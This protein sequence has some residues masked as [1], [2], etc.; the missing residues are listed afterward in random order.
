MRKIFELFSTKCLAAGCLVLVL[1]GCAASNLLKWKKDKEPQ[2]DAQ[3]PAVKILCLW[4]PAEG[5]R[6]DGLPARGFAGQIFFFTGRSATPAE[7]SG[8]V[9]VYVFDDQGT[10]EEQSKPIHQ[11]DF[12]SDAWKV[13]RQ[14]TDL[15]PAYHVFVPYV[16]KGHH[17]AHCALRVRLK[18]AEG[19]VIFS[20]MVNVTLSG[21]TEES[22]EQSLRQTSA[23]GHID[24]KSFANLHFEQ[25]TPP[26][27]STRDRSAEQP[28]PAWNR[29]TF[30]RPA[31]GP[32]AHRRAPPAEWS[33]SREGPESADRGRHDDLSGEARSEPATRGS[34]SKRRH[35]FKSYTIQVPR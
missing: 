23:T 29:P 12:L 1:S 8:D 19:P 14:E 31:A 15:G 13:H 3:N 24:K 16:R 11:F 10:R 28:L 20:E 18:P 17:Q 9:R 2:A 26:V 32:D 22:S 27:P 34:H 25:E 35:K 6:P 30:E 33:G 7:V 5:H 21:T 4:Q